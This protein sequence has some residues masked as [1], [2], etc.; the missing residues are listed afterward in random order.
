MKEAADDFTLKILLVASIISIIVN[1][2]TAEEDE[3]SI[4]WIDGFAILVAVFIV[5]FVTA[6]NDY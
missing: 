3:R 4:A 1:V 6:L 5:T 2:A